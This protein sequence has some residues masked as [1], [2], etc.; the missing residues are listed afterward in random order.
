MAN[1]NQPRG[2][3]PVR[4]LSGAK[5]NGQTTEYYIPSSDTNIYAIGDVVKSLDGAS[6]GQINGMTSI[7]VGRVTKASS[8]DTP[9]GVIVGFGVNATSLF[10]RTIPATK[11]QGY[12]VQVVDDPNVLFMVQ[13]NNAGTLSDTSVGAYANYTVTAIT[14]NAPVSATVLDT[15]SIADNGGLPLH[16]LQV[17]G[18][19]FT[20]YTP[21]L[22][23]FNLHELG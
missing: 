2:F 14:E 15:T 4:F 13:G 12:I 16:I 1:L 7:G 9:R 22:V 6:N 10:N 17:L 5:W 8:G 3:K 18:G 20:A 21:F 23:A 19:D 11:T